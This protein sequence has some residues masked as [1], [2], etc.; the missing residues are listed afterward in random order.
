MD[1]GVTGEFGRQEM[2]ASHGTPTSIVNIVAA[3]ADQPETVM[4]KPCQHGSDCLCASPWD[5]GSSAAKHSLEVVASQLVWSSDQSDQVG[6]SL[7]GNGSLLNV[8]NPPES[9]VISGDS[10]FWK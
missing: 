3:E 5:P 2:Q 7:P 9:T 8:S 4:D 6:H 10:V 1:F